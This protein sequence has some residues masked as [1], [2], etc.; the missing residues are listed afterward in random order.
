[1]RTVVCESCMDA[2]AAKWLLVSRC[3]AS[4][5]CLTREKSLSE[6]ASSGLQVGE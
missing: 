6:F 4:I 2:I 5:L 1:M 3:C